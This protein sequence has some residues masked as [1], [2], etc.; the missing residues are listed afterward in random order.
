ME[1]S[2]ES[3]EGGLKRR[4]FNT[5]EESASGRNDECAGRPRLDHLTDTCLF[6][7]AFFGQ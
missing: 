2:A 4:L 5:L 6:K 3:A 7:R 1:G